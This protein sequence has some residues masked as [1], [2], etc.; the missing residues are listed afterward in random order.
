[1]HHQKETQHQDFEK[2]MESTNCEC[3]C[4]SN[5]TQV[6]AKTQV[7]NYYYEEENI[8]QNVE[9]DSDPEDEH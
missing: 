9:S 7:P 1:V 4:I 6:I 8:F 5:K 3:N 2:V